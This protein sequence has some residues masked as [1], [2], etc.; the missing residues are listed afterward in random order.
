[1]S[2]TISLFVQDQDGEHT[3]IDLDDVWIQ[4][5]VIDEESFHGALVAKIATWALER[6]S[7]FDDISGLTVDDDEGQELEIHNETGENRHSW[8]LEV[9]QLYMWLNCDKHYCEDE[10]IL[11]RV[12]DIGWKWFDFDS[13][14]QEAEDMY[15]Q[16]FDGDY[17]EYAREYMDG[18]GESLSEWAEKYFDY[19]EYG[20][21]LV[22]GYD[23]VSWGSR[24]F[25]FS[26]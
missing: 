7:S 3:E 10:A 6:G 14:L 15:S 4:S 11:A 24:E 5:D 25:L 20:E 2:T 13:D 21:D 17:A 1:M 19:E 8:I 16:E 22:D 18:C 9:V 26:Q 12:D 23:R